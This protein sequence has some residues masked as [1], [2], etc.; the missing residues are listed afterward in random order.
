MTD[1]G[2]KALTQNIKSII[3]CFRDISFVLKKVHK[4]YYIMITLNS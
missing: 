3:T 1:T 2:F 4:N